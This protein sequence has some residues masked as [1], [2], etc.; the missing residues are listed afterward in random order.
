MSATPQEI[1]GKRLLETKEKGKKK[2]KKERPT[3]VH[4]ERTGEDQTSLEFIQRREIEEENKQVCRESPL[5]RETTYAF[6]AC[7]LRE[8]ASRRNVQI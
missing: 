6:T 4:W 7:G 5:R 1:T 8:K 3:R 2:G